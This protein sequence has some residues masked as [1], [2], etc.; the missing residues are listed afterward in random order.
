MRAFRAIFAAFFGL[1]ASVQIV[2]TAIVSAGGVGDS[3][4]V[5]SLWPSHPDALAHS[6]MLGVARSALS[7]DPLD[8]T[9]VAKVRELA[10]IAPL[11]PEPFLIEAALAQREQR[12]VKA[13]GLL[14]EARWRDPR[15]AAV[16]Y[17]LASNFLSSG[18][19]VEAVREMVNL[20][21]VVPGAGVSEALVNYAK[22]PGAVATLREIFAEYPSWELV[23]LG[24][25]AED[26]K[27]ADLVMSLATRNR[28]AGGETPP[29]WQ[30]VLL[31]KLVESGAYDKAWRL[32][33]ALTGY[34]K[35][36]LIF[37]PEFAPINAPAPFNWSLINNSSAGVAERDNGALRV[38][39]FE[40]QDVVLASQVLLL[41]PGTYQLGWSVSG[42]L[43]TAGSVRWMLR[44][45]PGQALV[46]DQ[47]A[48]T[49]SALFKIGG[50]ACRAQQ[51]HLTGQ[52]QE[53]SGQAD[54]RLS[55]L[56]LR[57]IQ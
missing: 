1:L 51:L 32:W 6:A 18:K 25:L 27:N 30:A 56:R 54:F 53:F 40:R 24:R 36:A 41:E 21:K 10:R 55:R 13:E 48:A 29:E 43:G 14:L 52:A 37:N 2:R 45:Q 22:T 4:I 11:A 17:L 57:K 7:G 26:P 42:D 12:W 47:P 15:N 34:S 46:L 38:L 31:S 49:G 5:S 3:K 19:I 20:P 39:Y 50:S 28:S 35:R 33:Q 9:T 8:S 16:R 23:V 44:C